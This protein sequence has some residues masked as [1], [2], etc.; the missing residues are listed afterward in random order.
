MVKNDIVGKAH[1]QPIDDVLPFAIGLVNENPKKYTHIFDD[2]TLDVIMKT[3]DTISDFIQYL[4]KKEEFLLSGRHI[5]IAGEEELLAYYL[6]NVD[7]DGNHCF[8][9]PDDANA[10][11]IDEGFWEEFMQHK[12]RIGQI[13]SNELSYVWDRLIDEF[14]KHL[15][16]GTQHYSTGHTIA[17]QEVALRLMARE[18]RTMRR[19]LTKSL[20][21]VV[22][23]ANEEMRSARV[24]AAPDLDGTYYVFLSLDP[25]KNDTYEGYRD[26]RMKLLEAYCKV[27][28]LKFASANDIVGIATEPAKYGEERSEDLMYFDGRQ[29]DDE[30]ANEAR[31]FQEEL[32]I[33]NEVKATKVSEPEYPRQRDV[34]YRKGRNRNK[35][36]PC[37]SGKKYKKCCDL[38]MQTD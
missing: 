7:K 16:N 25:P 14:T 37:G 12:D 23:R 8:P 10:I 30:L 18:N 27:T 38:L 6:K 22:K 33:L 29:W 15:L 19:M 3:A 20:S 32:N 28:R 2:S 21:A 17:E 31:R 13:E 5:M 1:F 35:P 26:V 4:K 9:F 24:I 34:E 36:C 11:L